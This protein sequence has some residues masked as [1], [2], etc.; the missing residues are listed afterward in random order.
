MPELSGVVR[1]GAPEER[2]LLP[3]IL[4][5][6]AEAFGIMIDVT[7]D[8]SSNLYKRMDEQRL[9]LA[10]VNCASV[11]AQGY[12]RGVDARTPCLGGCKMRRLSA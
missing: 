6:F 2:G 8:S 12:G 9:D 3:G 1:L 7:I 10:L 5:R 4:K 11:S